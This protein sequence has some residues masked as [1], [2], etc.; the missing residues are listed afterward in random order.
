MGFVEGNYKHTQ[1]YTTEEHT[2]GHQ[3]Y[4]EGSFFEKLVVVQLTKELAA[5]YGARMFIFVFIKAQFLS[6]S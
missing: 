4:V 3:L 1:T 6:H 5:F 2:N